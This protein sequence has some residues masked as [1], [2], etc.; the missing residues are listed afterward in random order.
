MMNCKTL[1][2]SI[3][4]YN[5]SIFLSNKQVCGCFSLFLSLFA[6][7]VKFWSVLI[8]FHELGEIELGFL[9]ELDLSYNNILEGEY[10][11]G[12]LDNLFANSISSSIIL[13]YY[14]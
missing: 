12:I 2:A 11:A 3:I 13:K 1:S 4:N 8:Q 9:E 5:S 7:N 10:L 6:F 14:D